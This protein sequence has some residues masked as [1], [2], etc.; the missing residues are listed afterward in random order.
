MP[1]REAKG[2]PPPGVDKMNISYLEGKVFEPTLIEGFPTVAWLGV[3]P[4]MESLL[5]QAVLL[6]GVILGSVYIKIQAKRA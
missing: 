2:D 3:Y 4:Y 5:P 1:R 6:L